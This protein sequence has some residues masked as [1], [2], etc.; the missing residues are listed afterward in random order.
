ML[1]IATV[2]KY[3][4]TSEHLKK[5]VLAGADA[6]RFN[7]SYRSLEENLSYIEIAKQ[8]TDELNASAIK[9][10][11]DFPLNK[12][13]LGDF[14]LKLF[15]VHEGDELIF[16]SENFSYDCKEYL[17]VDIKNLGTLLKIGQEITI[18]DGEISLQVIDII[19]KDS[20][21]MRI[22]NKG[23]I[24]YMKTF[25]IPVEVD[26]SKILDTYTNIIKKLDRVRCHYIALSY[27]NHELY[28][29]IYNV[30]KK[31]NLDTKIVVKIEKEMTEAEITDLFQNNN[32]DMILI[33]QGELGV[34][35]PYYKIGIYQ[36]KIIGIAKKYKKM[37]IIS[38]QILESTMSNYIPN[39][40]EIISLTN[41]IIDGVDGIMMCRETAINPRAAYT[42]SV[43]KK[44]INEVQN[45][46]KEKSNII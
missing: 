13:R 3:L 21:K 12:V 10:F 15:P 42:L 23:I 14:E 34:N 11:I 45:Y 33:D 20:V 7:F 44:I 30:I 29:K 26:E 27:Y 1:I 31:K 4:L 32:F 46:K 36:K 39:R 25:N 9:T 40:A 18:G 2:E 22:Q 43:A 35:M 6:L 38:T 19:D 8:V 37:I 5:L 41:N 17:P 24:Q 28:Q 16:K